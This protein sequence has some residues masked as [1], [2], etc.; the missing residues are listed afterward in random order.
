MSDKEPVDYDYSDN[1]DPPLCGILAIYA[2]GCASGALVT[3]CA[4]LILSA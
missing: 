1:G 2:M 4:Y 3:F